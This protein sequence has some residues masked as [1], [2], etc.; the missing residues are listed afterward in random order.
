MH[1]AVPATYSASTVSRLIHERSRSFGGEKVETVVGYV[2]V[3]MV[4]YVWIRECITFFV[5]LKYKFRFM[6]IIVFMRVILHIATIIIIGYIRW[7]TI[8]EACYVGG[9][10]DCHIF[11]PLMVSNMLSPL[12]MLDIKIITNNSLASCMVEETSALVRRRR[13][14]I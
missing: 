14:I 4:L 12:D 5:V 9:D 10:K 6:T 11:G 13:W 7:F 3:L 2:I 1:I 8:E